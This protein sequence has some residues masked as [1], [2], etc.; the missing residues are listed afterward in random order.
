MRD[1]LQ[2]F[3][4]MSARPVSIRQDP[5]RL[6]PLD[7]PIKIGDNQKVQLLGWKPTISIDQ[8]LQDILT[9]WRSHDKV[10]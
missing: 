3:T 7:E 8:A 4:A 2:R 10:M 9:F 1:I 6:R 5:A